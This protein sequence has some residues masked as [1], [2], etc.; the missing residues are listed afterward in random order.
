VEPVQLAAVL[1]GVIVVASMLSVELGVSVALLELGLGVLA[2]NPFGLNPDTS[3]SCGRTRVV[4][5][6]LR[7]GRRFRSMPRARRGREH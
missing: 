4:H 7:A 6:R 3:W 1:A 5:L 2:G